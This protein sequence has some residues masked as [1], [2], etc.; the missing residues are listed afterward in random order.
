MKNSTGELPFSSGRRIESRLARELDFDLL[1]EQRTLSPSER[2]EM[3]LRHSRQM[4]RLQ[5]AGESLRPSQV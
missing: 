5:T 2:L 3:F 4:A 1:N